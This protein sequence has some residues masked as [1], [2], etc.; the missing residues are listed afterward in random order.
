MHVLWFVRHNWSEPEFLW[1]TADWSCNTFLIYLWTL[2]RKKSGWSW[3]EDFIT[4][5]SAEAGGG[6]HLTMT[7]VLWGQ[8]HC[9]LCRLV[10]LNWWETQW[11]QGESR[12]WE[13]NDLIAAVTTGSSYLH[14][15]IWGCCWAHVV[16]A[17]ASF[18]N[19][20]VLGR[21]LCVLEFT[22]VDVMVD[23]MALVGA[24]WL[25]SAGLSFF[26]VL[27]APKL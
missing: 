4:F 2:P 5:G 6:W 18:F 23:R 13:R 25:W 21:T 17:Q 24:F 9:H 7:G 12:C 8:L 10:T 14:C 26:W 11:E 22:Y 3:C 15:E 1:P 20:A 27:M 16:L 19:S